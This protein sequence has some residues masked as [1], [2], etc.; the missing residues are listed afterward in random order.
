MLNSTSTDDYMPTGKNMS[1]VTH[2]SATLVIGALMVVV[3]CFCVALLMS[4]KFL[5]QRSTQEADDSPN[6]GSQENGSPARSSMNNS[7]LC[8]TRK[9]VRFLDELEESESRRRSFVQVTPQ[10]VPDAH[11]LPIPIASD[12]EDETLEQSVSRRHSQLG[13]MFRSFGRSLFNL[14]E[15]DSNESN[16][17]TECTPSSSPDRVLPRQNPIRTERSQ[18]HDKEAIRRAKSEYSSSALTTKN[19]EAK[20]KSMPIGMRS[21][22][23]GF[24]VGEE[25]E[26]LGKKHWKRGTVV[27]I[28]PLKVKGEDNFRAKTYDKVRKLRILPLIDEEVCNIDVDDMTMEDFKRLMMSARQDARCSRSSLSDAKESRKKLNETLARC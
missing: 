15:H 1:S 19:R 28:D 22:E 17:I 20:R 9:S 18:S 25:V 11:T 10:I 6:D 2:N 16:S 14:M 7:T 21:D 12:G 3:A 27:S 26:Y 23:K 24:Y 13:D 8:K 4:G 5:V